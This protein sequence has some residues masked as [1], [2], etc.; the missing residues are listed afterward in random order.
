MA[1][2]IV[3]G[4][5]I[6]LREEPRQFIV[7]SQSSVYPTKS[8]TFASD[9]DE[10]PAYI[11]ELPHRTRDQF[12]RTRSLRDNNWRNLNGVSLGRDHGLHVQTTEI[13]LRPNRRENPEFGRENTSPVSQVMLPIPASNKPKR[14]KSSGGNSSKH[15][16]LRNIKSPI[17][18]P[19]TCL[20]F[21]VPL[22]C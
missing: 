14:A 4:Q 16:W 12:S 7:S 17:G 18:E 2:S 3:A 13:P 15:N 22:V 1:T 8:M 19:H 11:N 10:P 20:P 6:E 5:T 21:S 9:D